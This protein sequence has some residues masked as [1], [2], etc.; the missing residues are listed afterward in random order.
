[1][2]SKPV[3]IHFKFNILIS[4]RFFILTIFLKNV[5]FSI[6]NTV[7][8]PIIDVLHLLVVWL[9]KF[10][11][12]YSRQIAPDTRRKLIEVI[13]LLSTYLSSYLYIWTDLAQIDE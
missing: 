4:N 1:M 2:I 11:T 3:K 5:M 7:T 9:D 12:V 13:N 6:G 8:C 10:S